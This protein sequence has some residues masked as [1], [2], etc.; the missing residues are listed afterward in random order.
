MD[1]VLKLRCVTVELDLKS[2]V[3]R[4]ERR[5]DRLTRA[6]CVI[7]PVSTAGGGRLV[8]KAVLLRKAWKR[9]SLEVAGAM[10]GP[11]LTAGDGNDRVM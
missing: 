4:S 3:N 2:C 11:A 1:V 5:G 8:E 10:L 6:G 9:S 7:A